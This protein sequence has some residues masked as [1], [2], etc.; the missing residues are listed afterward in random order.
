M[1]LIKMY[2]QDESNIAKKKKRKDFWNDDFKEYIEIL[3]RIIS[4]N[5]KTRKDGI[6]VWK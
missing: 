2:F 4:E 3:N 1:K 6:L 5:K